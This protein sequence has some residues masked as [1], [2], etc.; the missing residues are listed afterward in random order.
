MPSS[1]APVRPLAAAVAVA[2][3]GLVAVA[4]KDDDPPAPVQPVTPPTTP[5]PEPARPLLAATRDNRVVTIDPV[6]GTELD[7]LTTA[8]DLAAGA[9]I[10]DHRTVLARSVNGDVYVE[11]EIPYANAEPDPRIYRLP[12]GGGAP[13][14]VVEGFAPA[15]SP[16]GATLAYARNTFES[17]VVLRDLASGD[18]RV[19]SA[20]ADPPG[21]EFPDPVAALRFS[22]DGSQLAV[23]WLYEG[24][25]AGI[26]DVAAASLADEHHL[27]PASAGCLGHSVWLG[28]HRLAVAVET[29]FPY[30]GQVDDA[31]PGTGRLA[32]FDGESEESSA[33]I[34]LPTFARSVAVDGDTFAV[35][36]FDDQLVR[37]ENGAAQVIGSGYTQIVW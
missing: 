29:S 13:E 2:A 20:A 17:E 28:D 1:S 3:L 30:C 4:C 36:T 11:I 6:T 21:E 12:A 26:V 7:E 37:V 31:T 34:P 10:M 33:S 16:D 18:E 23:T 5:A 19:I 32:V 14:L 9:W 15:V 24:S 25:S 8:E 35:V 22:P 27:V